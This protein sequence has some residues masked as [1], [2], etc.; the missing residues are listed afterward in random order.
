MMPTPPPPPPKK[1]FE[2][3]PWRFYSEA[4]LDCCIPLERVKEEGVSLPQVACLARCNGAVARVVRPP[5][6]EGDGIPNAGGA[7]DEGTESDAARAAVAE[8]EA[9]FRAAVLAACRGGPESI[10]ASYSRALVRQTGDGHFS[11]IGAYDEQSDAVLVLDVARFKYSPHWLPVGDLVRAMR[12]VDGATGRPRGWL[13]VRAAQAPRS[14]LFTLG[15]LGAGAEAA[16]AARVFAE[17]T[18]PELLGSSP[19]PSSGEEEAEYARVSR[20]AAAAPLAAVAAFV[21]LRAPSAAAAAETAAAAAAL[22][23]ALGEGGGAAAEEERA[24]VCGSEAAAAD[25]DDDGTAGGEGGGPT[26]CAIPHA[27]AAL[28]A[29]LEAWPALRA[30]RAALDEAHPPAAERSAAA[31]AES[32]PSG[33][34]D[35]SN[36]CSARSSAAASVAGRADVAHAAAVAA[37]GP[38][39]LESYGLLPER[40][41][42]LLAVAAAAADGGSSPPWPAGARELL[43]PPPGSVLAAEVSYLRAQ[44]KE[45]PALDEA[46]AASAKAAGKGCG[47]GV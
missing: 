33:D 26:A 15:A 32:T 39:D 12:A 37:R 38:A 28:L 6:F 16:A 18:L 21:G 17:E 1:N 44:W 3:G 47:C 29:E 45:L 8:A 19:S 23:A 14:V 11:P 10:V 35:N 24:H 41:A 22:A 9:D 46:S 34:D 4:L 31:A 13:G 20:A 5:P 7:E 40:L 36:G 42:L 43:T 30:V 2:Q 25:D 27:A